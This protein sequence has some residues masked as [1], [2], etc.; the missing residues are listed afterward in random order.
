MRKV[1]FILLLLMTVLILL[2]CFVFG[3]TTV[4]LDVAVWKIPATG[5]QQVICQRLRVKLN[6]NRKTFGFQAGGDKLLLG[7][8]Q[9]DSSSYIIRPEV[10]T[11][12]RYIIQYVESRNGV[13]WFITPDL[14]RRVSEK[15]LFNF[16]ITSDRYCPNIKPDS[17]YVTK[18]H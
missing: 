16:I 5:H 9:P 15:D 14:K 13:A 7:A 11:G 8:I 1:V 17:L 2:P 4:H 12:Q 6:Y 10:L 18:K 3:Q